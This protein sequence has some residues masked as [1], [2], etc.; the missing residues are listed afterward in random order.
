MTVPR[1]EVVRKVQQWAI[2][3]DE[4]LRLA[5]HG[6]ELEAD[7]PYRLIAYHAQ[8]CAE[9]YLK[10][11]LV[12][13]SVDFPFTHNISLLLELCEDS[14]TWAATLREAERLSRLRH[15]DSLSWRRP[16]GDRGGRG[17]SRRY[18]N[19]IARYRPK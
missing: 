15:C 14:A 7:R 18:C 3:A 13:G 6:M 17:A 4:D 16:R 12:S 2:Y 8:Q 9:K 10:A 1:E 5:R 11:Y 19:P